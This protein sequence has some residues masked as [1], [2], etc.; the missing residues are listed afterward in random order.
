MKK[1]HYTEI[2]IL[3]AVL[4][5][6]CTKKT[7]E[8]P[9]EETTAVVE[10]VPET[11]AVSKTEPAAPET[12]AEIIEETTA[13]TVEEK[14]TEASVLIPHVQIAKEK[15][16][17]LYEAF[18]SA[19]EKQEMPD[20]SGIPAFPE[21][22]SMRAP[23]DSVNL[24]NLQGRWVHRETDS[25]G[26]LE[27]VLTINGTH[28]K[29]ETYRNGELSFYGWNGTGEVIL[30]DRLED[31][32]CPK[33]MLYGED[34]I[35]CVIYIRSVSDD[36]F[37][38]GGFLFEWEREFDPEAS[39]LYDTVTP[40]NLEGVWISEYNDEGALYRDVL[41]IEDG[42]G[43]L[44]ETVNGE[45]IPAWNISGPVSVRMDEDRL[46]PEL[47]IEDGTGATGGAGIFITAVDENCFYDSLFG[48]WWIR[49]PKEGFGASENE[50]AVIVKD[51]YIYT[52][53]PADDLSEHRKYS[54]TVTGGAGLCETLTAEISEDAINVPDIKS[55]V[56]E[57]DVNFDGRPDVL[58]SRGCIGRDGRDYYDCYLVYGDSLLLCE[59]F[60]EIP[61][62][63]VDADRRRVAAILHTGPE[64][65]TEVLYRVRVDDA[66]YDKEKSF[67]L[68]GD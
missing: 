6:G 28:G 31:G 22:Y 66:E 60:S 18:R 49:I 68:T 5:A 39:W 12:S 1:R 64:E 26:L 15:P 7:A 4:L 44:L 9:S 43:S 65:I 40:K 38:D 8:A 20:F 14:E 41:T 55:I 30:E 42:M 46:Q 58:L 57:R 50:D 67:R 24:L 47:L 59:G 56:Q 48:I 2:L 53:T 33:F 45:I 51:Q 63:A 61:D 29:V 36:T 16:S 27:E 54:V 25:E 13:E 3:M 52:I 32:K 10:T 21:D 62:P 34:G 35:F 23:Y 37:Y 19:Y 17:D 11:E